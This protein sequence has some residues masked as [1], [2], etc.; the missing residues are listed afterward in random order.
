[1]LL[2][3]L[4]R[5][6]PE[7]K[8]VYRKDS[9]YDWELAIDTLNSWRILSD[10]VSLMYR[11]LID[12]RHKSLHFRPETNRNDRELALKAIKKFNDIIINQFAGL[13][14]FLGLFLG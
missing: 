5:N 1:M 4:Y 9:F 3:E 8:K 2:R 7:Y 6:T 12:I 14:Q 11:D 13:D 10:N